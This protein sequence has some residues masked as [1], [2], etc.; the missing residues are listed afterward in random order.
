MHSTASSARPTRSRTSAAF[1]HYIAPHLDSETRDF[2]QGSG[3]GRPPAHRALQRAISTATACSA[4]SS[5]PATTL[6]RL[7]GVDLLRLRQGAQSSASSARF[8]DSK[9]APLFDKRLVRWLTRRPASLFGLGIPPAQ[10][11][12][13]SRPAS[14][15]IAAVLRARLERLACGFP[16]RDNYFAWQA[17]DR[18]LCPRRQRPAAA[19]SPAATSIPA[20]AR[21]GLAGRGE[22]HLHRPGP[23]RPWR[24]DSV[25]RVVLLDAQDWMTARP[26]RRPVERD[27]PH[28]PA[29]RP[30][31]LPHRCRAAR[32]CRAGS[33]R[34]CSIA[35]AMRTSARA[36]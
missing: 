19:L 31:H 36:S 22:A 7:Y 2:W 29:R 20:S 12:E 16:L 25:D 1:R 26:A 28:R 10:Y 14:G 30:R 21:G 9:I 24:R 15:D 35:G 3:R 5:A 11:R 33:H 34:R 13:L 4:A 8:F 32:S 18:A 17:F 27:H 23:W 6:A